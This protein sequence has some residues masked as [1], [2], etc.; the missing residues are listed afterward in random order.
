MYFVR[1][2]G[3]NS[4]VYSINIEQDPR[5]Q[6]I[7]TINSNQYNKSIQEYYA[8]SSWTSI[9]RILCFK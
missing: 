8:M 7:V 9:N 2:V 3:I 6:E 1:P 4:D 5:L